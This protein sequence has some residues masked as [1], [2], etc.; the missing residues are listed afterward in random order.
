MSRAK[1]HLIISFYPPNRTY[2]VEIKTD[3]PTAV[4]EAII[5]SW[6]F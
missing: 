1:T 2:I 4:V 3:V 6:P 5:D